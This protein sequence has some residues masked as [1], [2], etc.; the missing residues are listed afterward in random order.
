MPVGE[1]LY[2]HA[3]YI[4]TYKFVSFLGGFSETIFIL[5][6]LCLASHKG[7]LVNSVDPDQTPQYEASDQGLHCLHLNTGIVIKHGNNRLTR[8]PF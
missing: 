2:S 8:E 6:H 3:N 5:T 1:G 4:I 7:T